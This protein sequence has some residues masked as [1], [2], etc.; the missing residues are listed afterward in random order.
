MLFSCLV[1]ADFLDTEAYMNGQKTTL[2]GGYLSLAELLERFNRYMTEKI[3]AAMDAADT[4]VNRAR[5]Q[6][7]AG[8]RAAAQLVPGIFSLTV[9]TGGGKTLSSMAFAWS[10]P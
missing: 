7:L 8:C 4:P 9:P 3:A 5:Q 10:M 6:I 2:R 1:D